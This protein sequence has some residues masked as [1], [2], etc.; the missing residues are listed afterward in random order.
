MENISA[1]V[2]EHPFEHSAQATYIEHVRALS[3]LRSANEAR[4]SSRK[5]VDFSD[6]QWIEWIAD[7]EQDG[8]DQL[9]EALSSALETHPS[10]S[11][12]ASGISALPSICKDGWNQWSV[13][14]PRPSAEKSALR[15]VERALEKVALWPDSGIVWTSARSFLVSVNSRKE[16]VQKLFIRQ[17]Q[18]VPM[19]KDVQAI[20]V[21]E[22]KQYEESA[23][24]SHI[25]ANTLK[26]DDCWSSWSAME[27]AV[28]VDPSVWSD[29]IT[30]RSS[31]ETS[32]YIPTLYARSVVAA[33]TNVKLW[34]NY[35]Q[36][37]ANTLKDE[38]LRL[39]VM[40][41]AVKNCPYAGE[42]WL[43]LLVAASIA[44]DD[45]TI[46]HS[47]LGIA[48]L[49]ESINLP[50]NKECLYRLMMADANVRLQFDHEEAHRA[51]EDAVS[52]LSE[53]DLS[54]AGAALITWLQG[55]AHH[56]QM[57]MSGNRD[58]AEVILAYLGGE[59]TWGGPRPVFTPLQWIQFMW[60]AR[61]VLPFGSDEGEFI[62]NV[63]RCY[64]LALE[65]VEP[66]HRII[67]LQDRLVFEQAFGSYLST[68]A[69]EKAISVV[70]ALQEEAV[71]RK[72]PPTADTKSAKRTKPVERVKPVPVH[73]P[74][75]KVVHPSTTNTDSVRVDN[76]S[77]TNTDLM[78]DVKMAPEST[79]R[80]A[81][82]MAPKS[83]TECVY[84]KDLSFGVDDNRL[85]DFFEKDCGIARPR[86]VLIV[87]N[88]LGRSRGF[89]YAEFETAEDAARAIAMNGKSLEGRPVSITASNRG[90]SVKR[91][92]RGVVP[93]VS[94]ADPAVRIQEE[95]AKTN[96]YFRSLIAQ[97]QR[98]S[99]K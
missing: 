37:C 91:T 88:S 7:A 44:T 73:A 49:R 87:K 81:T 97:K 32:D 39:S 71:K 94:V 22:Q 10:P 54:L 40:E 2:D 95:K 93:A 38:T 28:A 74:E 72:A 26:A 6:S 45:D 51:Y 75:A 8:A 4:G 47:Y 77:A 43:E 50:G 92:D 35:S 52:I 55:E 64:N 89:G 68:C 25:V 23:G 20:V 61:K 19:P 67:I 48:A 99:N 80:V 18:A 78:E 59:T 21:A 57:L 96:D 11:V 60:V 79:P 14:E 13:F 85:C 98:H 82:N 41:R 12:L 70:T 69:V 83:F 9:A 84:I 62:P 34:M 86:R 56:D 42:L 76:T 16:E 65:S 24:L 33:P 1:Y 46:R 27:A 66:K 3:G 17:L 63:R 29:Y 31:V 53:V 36:Y 5:F 30:K 58:A 90:I 15:F